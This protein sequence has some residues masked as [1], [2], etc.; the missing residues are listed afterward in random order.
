M[1][2]ASS[3][4]TQATARN[5]G[6]SRTARTRRMSRHCSTWMVRVAT[7]YKSCL[8]GMLF[9]TPTNTAYVSSRPSMASA[10]RHKGRLR[11]W[12]WRN[13]IHTHRKL[14]VK[15]VLLIG[16]VSTSGHTPLARVVTMATMADT[17]ATDHHNEPPT[18]GWRRLWAQK[19]MAIR[20]ST[21]TRTAM[22]VARSNVMVAGRGT[23]SRN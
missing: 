14:A 22:S 5:S 11:P 1:A 19:A 16:M 20:A 13:P 3:A 4:V 2:S 6:T 7:T 21:Q 8:A 10:E 9:Q 15:A 17:A 23:A 18:L 12:C